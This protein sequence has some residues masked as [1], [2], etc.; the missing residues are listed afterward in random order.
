MEFVAANTRTAAQKFEGYTCCYLVVCKFF[1][2][3][4]GFP[5]ASGLVFILHISICS[6]RTCEKDCHILIV[7]LFVNLRVTHEPCLSITIV[8]LYCFGS[9]RRK[10]SDYS[11]S[12]Q[13]S[14]RSL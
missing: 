1:F 3:F 11:Y 5:L 8:S 9:P 13:R 4:F 14:G 7:C 6:S 10:F 12:E 2:V